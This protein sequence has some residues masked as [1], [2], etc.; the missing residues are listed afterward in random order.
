MLVQENR[1]NVIENRPLLAV[2]VGNSRIKYGWFVPERTAAGRVWPHCSDFL[3][4]PLAA[5]VPWETLRSWSRDDAFEVVAAG[6][7]PAVVDETA[8]QIR[9]KNQRSPWVPRER[10][11]LPLVIDVEQPE[12]VGLDRLFKRHRGEW[13]PPSRATG[14]RDRFR[15]GDH[16]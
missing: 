2:D 16:G 9:S 7:N 1:G 11:G 13:A 15:H 14:D 6:S 12:R 5:P 3:A 8:S 4:T 10:A